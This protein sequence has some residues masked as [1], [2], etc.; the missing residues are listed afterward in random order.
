MAESISFHPKVLL[1][2]GAAVLAMCLGIFAASPANS[3]AFTTTTY[4]EG[5][6]LPGWI[7]CYGAPRSLYAVYGWGDQHSVC[8]YGSR[9]GGAP[10]VQAC[11]GGPGQGV[12]AAQGT[13]EVLT[14]VIR[15]NAG[16][17]NI[18]HGRAYTA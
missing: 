4:C 7:A 18:V 12:Y 17:G 5:Q 2:L 1:A 6:A 15:N 10:V 9:V 8:V 14:P 16:G 13:S 11:S 3:Q